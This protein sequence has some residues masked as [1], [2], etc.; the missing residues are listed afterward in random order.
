MVQYLLLVPPPTCSGGAGRGR[1]ALDFDAD[2][3]MAVGGRPSSSAN[4]PC[5]GGNNRDP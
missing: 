4:L 3:S 1:L 5:Y 2:T